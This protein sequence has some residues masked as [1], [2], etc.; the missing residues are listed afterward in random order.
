VAFQ[1]NFLSKQT[2]VTGYEIDRYGDRFESDLNYIP[3]SEDLSLFFEDEAIRNSIITKLEFFYTK[4]ENL[5]TNIGLYDNANNVYILFRDRRKEFISDIY[6][7]HSQ[8]PLLN[9]HQIVQDSEA[10]QYH[11]PFFKDNV[12]VGNLVVTIDFLQYM[13]SVFEESYLK[14]IQWQW[15]I[16]LEGNILFNNLASVDEFQITRMED[17]LEGIANEDFKTELQ[18]TAII[19]GKEIEIISAYYP[20]YILYREFGII[21]SSQSDIILKSIIKNSLTITILTILLISLIIGLFIMYIRTQKREWLALKESEDTLNSIIESLPMGIIIVDENHI[22]KKVN[23]SARDLFSEQHGVQ[24]GHRLDEWFFKKEDPQSDGDGM[25]YDLSHIISHHRENHEYALLRKEIPLI[26]KGEKLFLQALVDI[27]DI[28]KARRQKAIAVKTKSEFLA[29]MSHEIRTPLNGIIGLADHFDKKNLTRKQKEFVTNIRKSAELLL[30]IVD[31]ILTFS[32]IEAGEMMLEEIPFNLREELEHATKFL[33]SKAR[34]K[35][36]DFKM[37]ISEDVPEKQIGD[38]FKIRQILSHLCDNA[39]KFTQKGIVVVRVSLVGNT[40]G[41]LVLK[42]VIE[43]TGIGIPKDKLGQIFDSFTRYDTSRS[44]PF[45]GMGLGTTLSKEMIQLLKGEIK[46]DS[47]SGLSSDPECPGT[48]FT[49]TIESFSDEPISKK[50]PVDKVTSYSHINVLII[51]DNDDQGQNIGEI[52]RNFGVQ[53]KTNFFQ[54]KTINLIESNLESGKD[55]YHLLILRDSPSFDAFKL[56]QELSR[57]KLSEKFLIILTSSNDRKGNYVRSKKLGIDHYLIEPCDHS[58][59]FNILQDNFSKIKLSISDGLQ[60]SKLKKNIHILM[61]EDNLINQKVAQTFFKNLGYEIDIAE[62]GEQ[63]IEMTDKKAYD[64]VFM[65]VMMPV[66]DG[67]EATKA[68]RDQGKT[69]PVIAITADVSEEA[70]ER[71]R[72]E[73]MNDYIPKPVKIDEIKRVLLR[74]FSETS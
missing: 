27:T 68:M 9:R 73:G 67:W 60:V 38:P 44:L 23:K 46:A 12:V 53:I 47:P 6:T 3:F 5:V 66:M 34:D 15:L 32:K 40:A 57:R 54:D 64:I 42:F 69:M 10:Y 71:A 35:K 24:T 63:V 45:E 59:L 49:F 20:V 65:D 1:K 48:R 74:W 62:N 4:Y 56:A 7:S 28:E 25:P 13:E 22:I 30:S 58:E 52:M 29:N 16:D 18:H 26:I 2:Q 55:R 33:A 37:E 36:I 72:E 17:I 19:D 61:A 50:I 70:R 14:D 31:D 11:L 21:F 39:I 51:K 8:R 41:K 43:D